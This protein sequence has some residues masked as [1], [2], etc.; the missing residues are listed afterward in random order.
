MAVQCSISPD[1]TG[2]SE[3]EGG[4]AAS[5]IPAAPDDA[6]E[7]LPDLRSHSWFW[8]VMIAAVICFTLRID[9]PGAYVPDELFYLIGGLNLVEGKDWLIPEYHGRIRLQ[10]PPLNYWL[11]GA[12]YRLFGV[13][14][15]QGRLPSALASLLTLSLTYVLGLTLFRSRR[16]AL[17]ASCAL[18]GCYLMVTQAH[19]ALT[20]SV[21]TFWTTLALCGFAL[22]L[23]T[24]HRGL[25]VVGWLG[26]AG[27]ALQKGPPGILI[28]LLAVSAWLLLAGRRAGARWRGFLNPW[29]LLLF[30]VVALPWPLLVWQRLGWERIASELAGEAEVLV[31]GGGVLSGLAGVGVLIF[32]TVRASFPW[33]LLLVHYRRREAWSPAALLLALW[34]GVNLTIFGLFIVRWRVHYLLPAMPALALLA[35]RV[36]AELQT[37]AQLERWAWR[38]FCWG[39]DLT[40]LG[41]SGLGLLYLAAAFFLIGPPRADRGLASASAALLLIGLA[42]GALAAVRLARRRPLAPGWV[43]TAAIGLG[44]TFATAAFVW[45][46]TWQKNPAYHLARRYLRSVHHEAI[47]VG[48]RTHDICW[49]W[50]GAGHSFAALSLD[51]PL[52]ESAW[53]AAAECHFVLSRSEV[54]RMMP[55]GLA[56]RYEEV[57]AMSV[58]PLRLY[59]LWFAWGARAQQARWAA[60]EQTFVLLRRREG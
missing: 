52:G 47:A 18:L 59:P 46:A 45:T 12:S 26:V 36:L 31:G 29:G 7:G 2:R 23:L 4:L 8:A 6:G 56:A 22:A 30:M 60:A 51:E 15:W 41:A 10:K 9:E 42:C 24:R 17:Y 55:P 38:L 53:A 16:A 14:A 49:A 43:V 25:A 3:V 20:D 5:P 13:G 54:L 37:R 50:L 21:L 19:R 57:A 11:V 33:S 35:G 58:N 28:P 44:L 48:L 32:R 40:L 39:A 34:L 27:A 1:R